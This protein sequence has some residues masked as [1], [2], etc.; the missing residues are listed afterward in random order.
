[1][2]AV[3]LLLL[4]GAQGGTPALTLPVP[5]QEANQLGI[6]AQQTKVRHMHTMHG[7]DLEEGVEVWRVE[8]RKV[9]ALKSKP[10]KEGFLLVLWFMLDGSRFHPLCWFFFHI[11]RFVRLLQN[12]LG[13]K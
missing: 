6:P 2:A 1:M 3:A 7:Q 11:F 8:C 12:S 9:E 5:R 4:S 13:W 10:R